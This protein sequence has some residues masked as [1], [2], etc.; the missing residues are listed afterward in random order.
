M[1]GHRATRSAQPLTDGA[2]TE[3]ISFDILGEIT[4]DSDNQ[5]SAG[6]AGNLIGGFSLIAASD[7]RLM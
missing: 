3:E 7:S 6:A 5:A 2:N 1:I 4:G